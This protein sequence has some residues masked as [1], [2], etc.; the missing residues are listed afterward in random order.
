LF[1]LIK[2]KQ[3]IVANICITFIVIKCLKDLDALLCYTIVIRFKGLMSS[4]H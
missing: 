2:Y 4:K 1:N 3:I